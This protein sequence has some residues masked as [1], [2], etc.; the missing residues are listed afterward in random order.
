M[1]KAPFGRA[2]LHIHTDASDGVAS[3]TEVLNFVAKQGKLNAIAITDHDTLDASLWA[4][5]RQH[6]YPFAI[7]PAVEVSCYDGHM[8][9]LWVT[10]PIKHNLSLAETAAAIHEQGGL[11]IL[12]HP[13]HPYI[14]KHSQAALRHFKRPEG[15]LEAGIDGLE[16]HNSGIAGTGFNWIAAQI[17]RKLGLAATAGSDAHTLGAIGTGETLFAGESVEDLRHALINRR[18]KAKGQAW[19]ITDYADYLKHER[20]AKA[21]KSSGIIKSYPQSSHT[22]SL[23]LSE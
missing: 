12:A 9:G 19:S 22:N 10:K 20:Q 3:V 21:R 5:E 23:Q 7:I 8:L 18:T 16:T 13:F 11:A 4:Y 6:L 14:R 17:A 1:N 15:L 2:D